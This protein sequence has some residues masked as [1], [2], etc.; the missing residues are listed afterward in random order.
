MSQADPELQLLKGLEEMLLGPQSPP[1]RRYQVSG[2][3]QPGFIQH[4]ALLEMPLGGKHLSCW[5]LQALE[6]SSSAENQTA[7]H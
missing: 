5:S 7:L 6:G 2:P 4:Q 3:P 1:S